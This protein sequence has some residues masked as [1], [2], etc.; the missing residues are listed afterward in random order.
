[1]R[2]EH[3]GCDRR[4]FL[5]GR[6]PINVAR[7]RTMTHQEAVGGRHGRAGRVTQTE[8]NG[9]PRGLRVRE[10]MQTAEAGRNL[11]HGWRNP[12]RLTSTVAHCRIAR[13]PRVDYQVSLPHIRPC[14]TASRRCL[15]CNRQSIHLDNTAFLLNSTTRSI[16]IH[17]IQTHS[18][19]NCPRCSDVYEPAIRRR[20]YCHCMEL[21]R[22]A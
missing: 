1:M 19:S 21:T 3:K 11:R 22:N 6:R 10:W 18:S 8:R 9:G 5:F 15:D 17:C 4:L 20:L 7:T 13:L 14:Q 12:Q 2:E 16:L